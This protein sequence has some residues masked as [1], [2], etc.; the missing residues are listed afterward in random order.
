MKNRQKW[1]TD[2]L[3]G[4]WMDKDGLLEICIFESLVHYVEKEKG[5]R[6]NLDELFKEEL[7]KGHVTQETVDLIKTREG[8]LKH[9]YDWIKVGRVEI[10]KLLESIQDWKEYER[11][12]KELYDED[13]AVMK[14][15]IELRGYMW[16]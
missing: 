9:C 11:I 1:L 4:D 12:E 3:K 15:I 8:L 10:Q 5:L 2:K 6:D 14:I 16:S 7:E 13:S